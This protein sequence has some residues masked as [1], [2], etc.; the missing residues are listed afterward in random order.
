MEVESINMVEDLLYRCV[1]FYGGVGARNL[2]LMPTNR[3]PYHLIYQVV[4]ILY[5]LRI[6]LN[7]NL[8]TVGGWRGP[9]PSPCD[10]K[11]ATKC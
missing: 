7:F 4:I 5:I 2:D 10:H 11:H 8:L 3:L 1:K 6:Y 9:D